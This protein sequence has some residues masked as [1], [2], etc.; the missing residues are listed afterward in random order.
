MGRMARSKLPRGSLYFK[1][2]R[3]DED[4]N[5][6]TVM[7]VLLEP[8]WKL[9]EDWENPYSGPQPSLLVSINE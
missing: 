1:D 7:G 4:Q 8:P 2:T 9:G 3:N 6:S 5:K